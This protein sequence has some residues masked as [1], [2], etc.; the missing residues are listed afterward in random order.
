MSSGAK[1][2]REDSLLNDVDA[3]MDNFSDTMYEAWDDVCDAIESIDID[4]VQWFSKNFLRRL[5]IE[6]P[7]VV[8]FVFAC[9]FLHLLN[10][11]IMPGI[12]MWFGVDDFF[13]ITNPVHYMRQFT[14]IFA[15]DGICLLYTSPS[16]R[17]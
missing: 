2:K 3:A 16:P 13:H 12:S 4:G 8:G 1:S 9:C 5:S 6:A 10:M 14:H 17:D 7:V 11:T 15:H